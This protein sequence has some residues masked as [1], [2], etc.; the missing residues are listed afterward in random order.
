MFA[1][2]CS[3]PVAK[4]RRL[5]GPVSLILLLLHAA[6]IAA[7]RDLVMGHLF[8]CNLESVGAPRYPHLQ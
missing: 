5:S 7:P 3:A 8:K 2:I 6:V 1:S 4:R